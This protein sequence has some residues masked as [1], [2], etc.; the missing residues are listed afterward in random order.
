MKKF[1]R[2]TIASLFTALTGCS[3]ATPQAA[4]RPAVPPLRQA[5]KAQIQARCAE[6][7][8]LLSPLEIRGIALYPR[9]FEL[10]YTPGKICGFL[11][12]AGFNRIYLHITSETELNEK[13]AAFLDAAQAKDL[14]VEL[15]FRQSNFHQRS[16]GN[17][18]L[19]KLRPPYPGLPEMLC[20]AAQFNAGLKGKGRIKALTVVA[21]PH[22]FN[23]QH[24]GTGEIFV[25]SEKTY[26]PGLDNDLMMG[27]TLDML[28]KM[29]DHSFPLTIAVP[30][31]Y[32][33]LVQ[34]GK[35]TRGSLRDFIN[36]RTL[37]PR[38][39][40]L[41]TGNKPTEIVSGTAAEFAAAPR[42]SQILL[43][44]ELAAHTSIKSAQLRRRDWKDFVRILNYVLE[45]HKKYPAF[46]GVVITPLAVFENIIMEQD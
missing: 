40:L 23:Q 25:W 36:T 46:R 8:K 31:F 41:S 26:G 1:I 43:G 7:K 37:T 2:L 27:R 38:L 20:K 18:I 34:A 45:K 19:Q 44:I 5:E 29:D 17:R 28:K 10:G 11:L 22:K 12:E 33:E 16:R 6:I 35:L 21:E 30:D 14:P 32:Q 13:L 4:V 15:I 39:M 9:A 3:V 42:N 24:T